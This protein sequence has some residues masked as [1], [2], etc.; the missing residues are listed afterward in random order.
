MHARFGRFLSLSAAGCAALLVTACGD[1][2][3]TAPPSHPASSPVLAAT[4]TPVPGR[5]IVITRPGVAGGVTAAAQAYPDQV[6]RSHAAAGIVMMRDLTGDQVTRLAAM[7]GVEQVV[8][9]QSLQWIPDAAA[10]F[11]DVRQATANG[12]AAQGT[13]QSGAQFFPFQWNMRQIQAPAAWNATPGGLG[14]MVCILDSGVDP[15]HLDL[16]GK[17]DLAA[18]AS[19]VAAEPFIE[20]LNLHGTF[21]SALVSSRGIAMASVAPDARLCAVKVLGVS[22]SGSFGDIING[23]IF[24]AGNGSD[25]INMS[26][27]AYVDRAAAGVPA[28]LD[29]L[30][31]AINIAADRGV[32]VVTSSGNDGINL[33][34][35]APTLAHIPSQLRNVISVGATAP[36]NQQNFDLITSYSNFGGR[37]G[38]HMVAPGGDLVAG[39]TTID[40]VL[41]ACSRFNVSFNCT[42]GNNYLFGAGTS[43]ASPL[44][45]G[46]GAVVESQGGGMGPGELAGCLVQSS[47]GLTPARIYGAGRLNVASAAGC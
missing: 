12:P 20:D 30:Q 32:M 7:P 35:D 14:R 23:I 46:A 27:G 42:A 22:G 36:V 41:S 31:R 21:V 25:V 29:A 18:S 19:M 39:G 11:S 34:E 33:D 4:L 40:L 17:V 1:D 3:P 10:I 44:V 16:N 13:D 8:Q 45:A 6:E 26:L 43:F 24:A 15:G 2:G 47:D 38:L 9:D 5:Y 37:T 28:L